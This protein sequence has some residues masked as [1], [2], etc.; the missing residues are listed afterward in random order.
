MVF[1]YI[2]DV[3]HFDS[4]FVTKSVIVCRNAYPFP[5]DRSL[6]RFFYVIITTT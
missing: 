1:I 4:I 2:K 5:T 3:T 6:Y